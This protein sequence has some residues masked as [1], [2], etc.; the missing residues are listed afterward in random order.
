MYI[1]K[2]N[3]LIVL[4]YICNHALYLRPRS[5]DWGPNSARKGITICYVGFLAPI[6]MVK[7]ALSQKLLKYYFKHIGIHLT[8]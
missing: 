1:C 2:Y 5:V 6:L 7:S 4:D 8:A 3:N